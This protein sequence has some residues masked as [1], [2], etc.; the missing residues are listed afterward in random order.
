MDMLESD[1]RMIYTLLKESSRGWSHEDEETLFVARYFCDLGPLGSCSVA[2]TVGA[3]SRGVQVEQSNFR[4]PLLGQLTELPA[5]RVWLHEGAATTYV[6]VTS[7]G[8]EDR[9]TLA[10]T[11]LESVDNDCG[12]GLR[13]ALELAGAAFSGVGAAPSQVVEVTWPE[14]DAVVPP[15]LLIATRLVP[16][17]DEIRS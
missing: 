1:P 9:V 17:L 16:L 4:H 5:M 7:P 12:F 3:N 13:G 10:T 8:T 15:V 2:H 14:R 6:D 11:T